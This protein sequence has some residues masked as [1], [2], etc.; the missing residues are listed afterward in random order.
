VPGV[1]IVITDPNDDAST[2]V[3]HIPVQQKFEETPLNP[4]YRF[5]NFVVGKNNQFVYAAA[6][7]ATENL[8]GAYN[9]LFIYSKVGLG[10]T[11][12][13]QA[14]GNQVRKERPELRV[15]YVP[16]DIFVSEFISCIRLA[17]DVSGSQAFRAKYRS[18]DVLL[19]DDIQG[20]EKKTETQEEFF[21]TYND[22]HNRGK[23]I[24]F[25]SDRP[26]HELSTLTER[27]RSR[28]GG[29]ILADISM[30]DFETRTV[31]LQKKAS[32]QGVVVPE[33]ATNYIAE[34]TE[35][36]SISIR[37]MIAMQ[38][39]AY[40]YAKLNDIPLDVETTMLALKGIVRDPN[41]PMSINVILDVICKY[42]K[43]TRD[44]LL[45]K[46]RSKEIAYPRQMCMYLITEIIPMPLSAVGE[47]M[48]GR[49]HTTV[50]HGRDKIASDLKN[51][52]AIKLALQ[53]IRNLIYKK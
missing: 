8:G 49:D 6:R 29:G 4:N 24:V 3:P 38:K 13:L 41:E 9:P 42:Y 51:N 27:L 7:A 39:S 45:G 18:A 52:P 21:N 30:P 34:I 36:D 23:Q 14:I 26:P 31:I 10:K 44:D 40:F 22:L 17:K 11:H 32:E 35:S 53:E 48:G 50:M 19:I 5:D 47:L 25:T 37:E 46:K 28:L 20:L 12:I 43:V 16:C 2:A 1:A 33:E 15:V